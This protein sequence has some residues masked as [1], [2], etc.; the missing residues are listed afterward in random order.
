MSEPLRQELASYSEALNSYRAQNWT[1]A[2]QAFEQL[3]QQ[4]PDR[5]LYTL[6]LERIAHF[7]QNPPAPDWDGT[8]TFL[9]K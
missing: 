7:A 4:A 2:Q 8:Y 6:Y 9:T 5:L 1:Q 3:H